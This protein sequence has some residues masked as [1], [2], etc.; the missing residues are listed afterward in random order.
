MNFSDA[1]SEAF[2]LM[3]YWAIGMSLHKEILPIF[4]ATKG[5]QN[6]EN[7][8]TK[9]KNRRSR[10]FSKHAYSNYKKLDALKTLFRQK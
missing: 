10:N 9:K 4:S 6:Y 8:F 3:I 7:T 2:I 1:G 5:I